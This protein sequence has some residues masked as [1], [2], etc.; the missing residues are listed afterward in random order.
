LP[1]STETSG[2]WPFFTPCACKQVVDDVGLAVERG[3]DAVDLALVLQE[4]RLHAGADIVA[5]ALGAGHRELAE[6]LHRLVLGEH[7]VEQLAADARGDVEVEAGRDD[8]ALVAELAEQI[9][10]SLGADLVL[11]GLDVEERMRART[12]LHGDH[13]DLGVLGRLEL[14]VGLD[15]LAHG[16]DDRVDL[17]GDQRVEL[18]GM[19]GQ[20]ALRV[21]QRDVPALGLGRRGGGIGDAG[22]R[23]RRELEADDAE[24]EGLSALPQT[25][26]GGSRQQNLSSNRP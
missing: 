7:V 6:L 22:M 9:E 4:Q 15:R 13:R 19:L 1:P 8:V 16:D 24:L 3:P 18:L 25:D 14:G 17:L 12:R 5:P 10:R 21:Q 2:I 26:D 20:R 23:L 11:I